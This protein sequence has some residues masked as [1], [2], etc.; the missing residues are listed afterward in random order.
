MRIATLAL[1][2]ALVNCTRIQN[3]S[4]PLPPSA[5]APQKFDIPSRSYWPTAGWRTAKPEEEGLKPEAIAK[6]DQYLFTR[7]GDDLDRNG[8]RTDGVVIVRGGKIV[9]ERYARGYDE[10]RPH[11]IWSSA[12]SFISALIGIA[13]KEGKLSISDSASKYF[14]EMK[15]GQKSEI[16]VEHILQMSSGLAWSEGYEASPLDSS[17]IAML[18]TAGRTDMARY[19]ASYPLRYRPGTRWYYSSGDTNMLSAILRKTMSEEEY[20]NY[21]WAKLFEPIGMKNMTF[22][23]DGSGTF[24]GSSYIY[25]SPRELA[26]FGFL[27]LNDGV[28]DGKRILPEGWVTLSRTMAPAFYAH[29]EREDAW[30]GNY[31]AQ[32]WQNGDAPGLK[33]PWPDAPMD[34]YVASGHWGQRIYV[35]PS[36]DIVAVRVGDD[37]R[38]PPEGGFSD[39]EFL[40]WI[41]QAAKK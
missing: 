6:L 14:A 29:P 21:P 35:I 10:S 2:F 30:D 15:D 33:A 22:E 41:A 38:H 18:Y 8:V 1:F 11:L 37:R 13:V 27:Y 7:T 26:K 31:G 36:L 24:V 25:G 9:Y 3:P 17:V 19:T 40:K 4:E 39:N 32:W 5:P 28:W 16:K 23:R 20:Q 34:T 12:K